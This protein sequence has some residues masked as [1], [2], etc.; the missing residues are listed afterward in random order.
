MCP[1]PLDTSWNL[2]DSRILCSLAYCELY[3]TLGTFFRRFEKL[4]VY[5]TGREDLVYDDF[6]SSYHPNNAR[7][8]HVVAKAA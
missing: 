2:V 8:F 5:K 7:R 1:Y 6:F 3:L 4:S